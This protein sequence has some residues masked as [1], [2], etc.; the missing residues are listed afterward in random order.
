MYGTWYYDWTQY[1]LVFD[2]Q[3]Q[4]TPYIT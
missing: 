4:A 3:I 2:L 1:S